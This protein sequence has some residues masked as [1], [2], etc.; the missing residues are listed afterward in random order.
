MAREIKSP[1]QNVAQKELIAVQNATTKIKEII[2]VDVDANVN[3]EETTKKIAKIID[4]LK[5]DITDPILLKESRQSLALS[6]QRWYYEYSQNV[7]VLRVATTQNINYALARFK[8]PQL[9]VMSKTY[10]IDLQSFQNELTGAKSNNEFKTVVDKFRPFIDDATKGL[11]IVKDYDKLIKGQVKV[12]ASN[13][14]ISNRMT[15]E[16]KPYKVN[17]RNRAEMFVRYQANLDDLQ[18]LIADGVE[19]A[20]IS[21]HADA[22]PRC[23]RYQGKLYSLNGT[24]GVIN[25]NRYFPI[26]DALKGPLGDGNGCIS[27]YN[28]RHRLIEYTPNSKPPNDYSKAEMKK[29]YEVDQKQRNY[30]NRIRQLKTEERLMRASG[31]T[32]TARKL[33]LQWRRMNKDYEIYSLENG[34]AYYNWRT[35]IRDDETN[36]TPVN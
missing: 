28:C 6:T 19:Y 30:E 31:D 15:N 7:K 34:R 18:R 29:A 11:P 22:S 32:E 1:K 26:E 14:P 16:G 20:W 5:K 12:L 8:T 17:L 24:S 9:A 13:P 4:E 36:V 25:G 10:N 2:V 3:K 27:G 23:S 35:I 33:R 21:T